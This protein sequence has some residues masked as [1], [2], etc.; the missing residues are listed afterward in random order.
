MRQR[1]VR[2]ATYL[3]FFGSFVFVVFLTHAPYFGLPYFWD[4]LGQ[5]VPSALDIYQR[6]RVGAALRG[7]ERASTG[8]DGVSR[9][10]LENFRLFDCGHS[11]RDAGAGEL[12]QPCSRSC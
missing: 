7:S 1:S 4:E 6:R 11:R 10:G 8:R 5:F 2:P 12:S 9:A 3:F